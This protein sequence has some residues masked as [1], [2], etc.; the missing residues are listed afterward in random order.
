MKRN[1]IA[2]AVAVLFGFPAAASAYLFDPQGT[3]G[4]NAINITAFDW[5]PTNV[6]AQNGNLAVANFVAKQ[7]PIGLQVLAQGMLN[8]T[9]GTSIPG[10]C[11]ITQTTCN[12]GSLGFTFT[13]GFSENVTSVT[14]NT[15]FPPGTQAGF[16]YDPTQPSFFQIFAQSPGTA[17]NLTGTG[18]DSG[19]LI[20]SGVLTPT[21]VT[22]GS[23][24][25]FPS[26][27]QLFDATSDGDQY[28]GTT[29]LATPP[30]GGNNSDILIDLTVVTSFV[31]PNYFLQ[32][33]TDLRFNNISLSPQFTTIDPSRLFDPSA[34]ANTI[35]VAPVIGA[36]NGA[37]YNGTNPDFQLQ[38]DNNM[39][40][41]G[42]PEPATL[43]LI[44]L[45]LAGLGGFSRRRRS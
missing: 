5:G 45:G 10:I 41:A 13:L 25:A 42:V 16:I 29:T 11:T 19:T 6:L 28:S 37:P 2:A 36:S 9:L 22:G 12:T 26:T 18:F 38:S 15:P 20:L 30:S 43:A 39:P 24:A 27:G 31:N 21:Q 7:G 35:G 8:N 40:I 32:P 44:G 33:I 4:A 1:T 14:P 3:S 23:F 17:N 34:G